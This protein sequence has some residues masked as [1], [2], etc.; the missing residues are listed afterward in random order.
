[1]VP[2]HPVSRLAEV[3]MAPCNWLAGG[4][5][6]GS[7][8]SQRPPS[9]ASGT[10]SFP[11]SLPSYVYV[12]VREKGE[13]GCFIVKCLTENYLTEEGK[14]MNSILRRTVHFA[15]LADGTG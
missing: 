2:V 12:S 7:H 3:H 10:H 15:T 11:I 4:A 8:A 6:K 13:R 9:S 1:M 5:C 14:L